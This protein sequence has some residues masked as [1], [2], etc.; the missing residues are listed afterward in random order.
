[1][2]KE[3]SFVFWGNR[4]FD[5][6][7]LNFLWILTVLISFGIATG[8]AT[9]ALF[10]SINDG[11]KGQRNMAKSYLDGLKVFWK[12]GTIVWAIQLLFFFVIFL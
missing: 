10:Y 9:M 12:Q 1:M 2:E 8:A 3:K 4:V 5:W 7:I 6:M 11:M